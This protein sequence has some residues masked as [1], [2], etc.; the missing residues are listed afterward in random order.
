M[1]VICLW[2][3]SPPQKKHL[4]RK[5]SFLAHIL[6]CFNI[7]RLYSF[8]SSLILCYESVPH[9][10]KY[11]RRWPCNPHTAQFHASRIKTSCFIPAGVFLTTSCTVD[12]Q[13]RLLPFATSNQYSRAE[14]M[15]FWDGLQFVTAYPYEGKGNMLEAWELETAGYFCCETQGVCSDMSVVWLYRKAKGLHSGRRACGV[16]LT[17]GLYTSQQQTGNQEISR[18]KGQ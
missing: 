14:N 10:P 1:L 2:W 16:G 8:I 11:P 6:R 18:E 15:L 13:M 5:F 3:L 7:S 17:V 9:E 12:M 4:C